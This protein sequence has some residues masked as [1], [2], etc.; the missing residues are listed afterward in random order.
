MYRS[1]VN[2]LPQALEN[3]IFC[4]LKKLYINDI[5]IIIV[6][7]IILFIK[8]KDKY[9]NVWY[10]CSYLFHVLYVPKPKVEF[11]SVHI[12]DILLFV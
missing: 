4:I 12:I 7:D 9:F 5:I 10:L 11:L 3:I 2:Y 6:H 8:K 1:S